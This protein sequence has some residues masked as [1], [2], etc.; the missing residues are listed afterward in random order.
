MEVFKW[1]NLKKMQVIVEF[2]KMV[3][4]DPVLINC[5]L[6]RM[7]KLAVGLEEGLD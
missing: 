5:L 4:L 2:A 7:K 3:L 1:E 6:F